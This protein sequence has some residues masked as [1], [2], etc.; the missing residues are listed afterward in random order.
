MGI[1]RFMNKLGLYVSLVAIVASFGIPTSQVL[2]TDHDFF[3]ANDILFFDPDSCPVGKGEGTGTLVGNDNVE[4]TLRYFV[5]KGLTLAQASGIVGN[6]FAESGMN[7]AIIQG[8]LTNDTTDD[9]AGT[10]APDDY[11]PVADVGFGIAQWTTAGR[12]EGLVTLSQTGTT[13]K[14]TDLSLQLDYAWQE[15]SGPYKD[16]LKNLKDETE[17]DKAAFVF[18]RDY[19]GSADTEEQ[20]RVNRGGGALNI[21]TQ[22]RS[23]IP[24]G[25]SNTSA[26]SAA[27]TGSGEASEF[28]DGFA[29]YNQEDP[30]WASNTYG[31][32][33]TIK[34]SGCGPSAMAMIITALTGQAVTPADTAAY[35]ASASPTTVY[36]EDG[37][38]AGSAHNLHTVIGEHWGLASTH[39]GH[40]VAAI[41]QGLRNGGL[42]IISGSGPAP[43]TGGGHFIVIRAVTADGQWLVGDSNGS[44]GSSNSKKEWDPGYILGMNDSG[45]VWLLTK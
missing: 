24:D 42:V 9:D 11:T 14:I 2:A 21:Y 5:G 15:L 38:A 12:Q 22:F 40:D 30:Q 32:G 4:K 28:V 13:R 8:N 39:V 44:A 41:N 37:V 29:I 19:E 33:G 36:V 31:P 20:V 26:N 25:T 43:F 34:S 7:P 17:A 16:A 35:G 10:I 27:C 6:F 18:H 3:S 45:Y 1:K 23:K